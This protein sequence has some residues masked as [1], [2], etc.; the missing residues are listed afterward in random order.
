M[1]DKLHKTKG[2]VLRT[3]KYGETSII[4]TMFTE[5]FGVQAYLVNGVRTSTKKGSG[6]ANLFQP[7]A[8]LD[9]VVYHNELK[10]LNRIKEFK[11]ATI[12][13]HILSD[14]RKN[15]VALFMVELLT[16]CL[17]QP[18]GNPDLF[19]FAEDCLLNLDKSNMAVMANMSLFFALHLTHFFGFRMTDDYSSE[20]RFLDLKEG[21][22]FAEQ[23][24]HPHFLEDKQA[25]IT[26]QLLKVQQPEE[27]EE[28]KLNHDFRRHLLFVY[29]TYY[30]L[31]ITD[32]G[33]M[34]SLPVLREVL[35]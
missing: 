15:A 34:K 35:G 2:I 31:H 33:T 18:E 10:H 4:V 23:P 32:F 6:K 14:V 16:K 25:Y 22:F 26:S 13:Q 7:T 8:I 17:K 28:I 20:N 3:V 30:A 9:L 24:H 27:L 29:E 11:W 12:Y 5:L 19:S 1:P 21:G